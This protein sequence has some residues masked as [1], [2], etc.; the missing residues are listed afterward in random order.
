MSAQEDNRAPGAARALSAIGALA[1]F[2]PLTRI[3]SLG[4][5]EQRSMAPL[6]LTGSPDSATSREA[7]TR[8]ASTVSPRQELVLDFI[9]SRGVAGCTDLDLERHF[10]DHGSTY[11]TRRAELAALGLVHDSGIRVTQDNSRRIVWI[12]AEHAAGRRE[13]A[14]DANP[15]C[16]S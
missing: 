4:K 3:G 7:V 5:T 2:G 6:P 1:G 11:R 10:D 16:G 8:I 12:A 13:L 15:V 9:R 14:G